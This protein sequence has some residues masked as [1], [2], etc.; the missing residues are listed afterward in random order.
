MESTLNICVCGFVV[1]VSVYVVLSGFEE[2]CLAGFCFWW[3]GKE[4]K[5]RR[6]DLVEY[7]VGLKTL[8][9]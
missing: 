3:E 6:G 8:K 9:L 7:T 5:R 4:Y 1:Y 2:F